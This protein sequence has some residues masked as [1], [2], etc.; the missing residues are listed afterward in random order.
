MTKPHLL[1]DRVDIDETPAER[2]VRRAE[3]LRIHRKQFKY[4]KL[5][6]EELSTMQCLR[7]LMQEPPPPRQTWWRK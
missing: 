4:E 3:A 2:A 5:L 6:R 1:L 7:T